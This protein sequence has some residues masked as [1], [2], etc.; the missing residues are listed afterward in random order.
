MFSD[1]HVCSVMFFQSTSITKAALLLLLLY[2]ADIQW[3]TFLSSAEAYYHCLLSCSPTLPLKEKWS[4]P[5]LWIQMR[6][7]MT[8]CLLVPIPK[9]HPNIYL[10]KRTVLVWAQQSSVCLTT[11]AFLVCFLYCQSLQLLCRSCSWNYELFLCKQWKWSVS[12]N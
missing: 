1:H 12:C 5:L 11:L 7:L 4:V 10:H 2:V 6:G 9:Q 3:V 8:D